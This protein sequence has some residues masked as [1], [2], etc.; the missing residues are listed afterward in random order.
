MP[1]WVFNS[2]VVSGEKSE[3]D[4]MV[5]QLNQPFTTMHPVGYNGAEPIMEEYTYKNPVI[6]FWNIVAPTD[7]DSYHGKEKEKVDLDNFIVSF[8]NAVQNDNSWYYW[9]LRNWGTKWDVAVSNDEEY[10]NT[11]M[12]VN[13]D[14]SVMYHFSTA[15]SPVHEVLIK[16]SNQYPTLTFDYE[17]EEEQGWGGK[18]L[19]VNGEE[20]S[21]EQW[22]IPES[23]ADHKN[24][25]RDCNC[26]HE[27]DPEYWYEDCPIDT[28]KYQWVDDEW[29]EMSDLSDT[30]V[31]TNN[32]Q[33]E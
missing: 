22:D 19:I 7:L 9:N 32:L 31:S 17:Y 11:T 21:S 4:K 2:L 29:Q 8:S 12:E 10:S 24:L 27:I 30:L 14:G 33:G 23:H 13:D 26:E 18:S 25:N 1:N 16:L 6:A 20:I 28:T 3:L 15:W 5:A